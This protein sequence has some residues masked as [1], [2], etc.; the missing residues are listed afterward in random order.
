MTARI[1]NN[2]INQII[3]TGKLQP[4]APELEDGVIGAIMLEKQAF[5]DVSSILS[6]KDFYKEAHEI[7][8]QGCAQLYA[9]GS[10][11]DIMTVT[12]FLRKSGEIDLVGGAYYIT[13]LTNRVGS[14]ANIEF[15]ARIIKQKAILRDVIRIG[16]EISRMAYEEAADAF[17]T[18]NHLESELSLLNGDIN[19]GKEVRI[20]TEDLKDVVTAAEEA[21]KNHGVTGVQSAFGLVNAKTNG[22]QPSDLIVVAARPG[23]GK[24]AYAIQEAIFSALN[25]SLIGNTGRVLFFSLEM[26][27]RQLTQRIISS[28]YEI[29]L[30]R[31]KKGRFDEDGWK[32]LN[33]A[34]NALWHAG[35]HID[36]TP[37]LSIG[38]I[39]RR[40]KR[41][42]NKYGLKMIFLDYMQLVRGDDPN[43]KNGNREQEVSYVSRSL[44]A[45]AKQLDIPVFALAQLSRA[46]EK[47]GVSAMPMLS[48]L[49]ES[50]AIEQDADVVAT[51]YR[52][53]YY[54]I[55]EHEGEDLRGQAKLSFLKHRSG[56]LGE[57]KLKWD[58]RFTR[59]S[60]YEYDYKN[61]MPADELPL[62]PPF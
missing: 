57:V 11:I 27:K 50:G 26:S 8:F 60:N 15:H 41:M 44:K 24:T 12:D 29:E 30:T 4:Q 47:R 10:P 14:S 49:R 2:E 42:H 46:S 3:E 22:W 37:A 53:E 61:T 7:I 18:L 36:D 23:M 54:G 9:T 25:T 45:L 52:P 13:Q 1:R 58:G 20:W 34:V 43:N 33:D 32:H 56:S 31:L 59:F 35:I 16:T 28:G 38:E 62:V 51:I 21:A 39:C 40:A 19:K 6:A 5:L 48:D 17:E 55:L